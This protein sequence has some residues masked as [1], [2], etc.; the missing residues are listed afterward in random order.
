MGIAVGAALM[1]PSIASAEDPVLTRV[2]VYKA[3]PGMESKLEEGIK[4]HNEFHRKQSD[5]M[6]H[7]TCVVTSG[8]DTGSYLRF[9]TN[10]NWKDFDAEAAGQA[11]DA[12]DSAMTVDP[13]LA[14]TTVHY[15]RFRPELSR[16]RPGGRAPMYLT[17]FYKVKYG[18]GG[19]FE[20]A[21][22]RANEAL[23]KA[24]WPMH[25]GWFS[26]VNGGDMNTWVLSQPRERFADLNPG[27]KTIG[28]MMEETMG[29]DE[30]DALWGL[31]M[32]SVESAH[33][34]MMS[35]PP[36]LSYTPAKR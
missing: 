9:A 20:R 21:L 17:T 12:A 10:R 36:G 19:D 6:E 25:H 15:Y 35:C 32:G 13:Y 24:N 23:A 3:K 4:K 31:F 8:P 28:Q 26:L 16:P 7:G 1:A 14:S 2:V 29:R 22:R 11:A 33:S 27:E 30:A 18:K 5:P 34:Q